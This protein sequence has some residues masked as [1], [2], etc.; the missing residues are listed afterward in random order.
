MSSVTFA[1]VRCALRA[2]G[3]SGTGSTRGRSACSCAT[4][5]SRLRKRQTPS[6]PGVLPVHVLVGRAHE[7]RVGPHRV[8]AVAVGV[9]QRVDDVALRLRHLRAVARDHPL[10]EEAGDRLAEADQ[11]LLLHHLGEE[12]RVEQ[13]QDGVLDA[14]DVL[15]DRHP[16]VGERA[17]ERLAVVVRVGVA[18]EV[19]G[20][21]DEGVHRVRL[22][23]RR[24]AA[25]RAR[26][27]HPVLAPRAAS[28]PWAGSP[29]RP[30]AARAAR[31]RGPAPR[32]TSRSGRS[33]SGS[34]S[35]AAVRAASRAGGSRSSPRPGRAPRAT[36]RSAP[37]P[38]GCEQAGERA[39]VDEHLVLGV[40]DEGR[41]L[42]D[43]AFGRPHDLPDRQPVALREVEVALVV[44][45]DGHDR[46]GAVP[47]QDVVGDPDRDPLVVHRV[48]GLAAGEDAVLLL[49]LALHLGARAAAC[50]T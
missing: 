49:V 43:L 13:V 6:R 26:R 25:A 40:R 34:P 38:P 33:G 36:R 19:P 48:D 14:A 16:V 35:S 20:R 8:R 45:G 41:A 10:V 32:R 46:A 37:S 29:P 22:A 18:D 30:G 39:R 17:R 24:P 21:V 42:L 31:R 50:R 15:V 47:H 44:R 7:E 27:R 5:Q 3:V 11:A 23:P 12:P 9:A 28:A 1:I 2:S 4:R